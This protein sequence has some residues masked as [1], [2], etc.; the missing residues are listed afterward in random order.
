[1]SFWEAILLGLVQGLSEFVPISSTAHL[2]LAGRLLGRIDPNQPQE[3]TA[4][5]AVIQLGTLLAVVYYFRSDLA[6]IARGFILTHYVILR[7]EAPREEERTQSRLGWMVI[8][9]SI[10][11]GAVGLAFRDVIEGRL[12]K[13]LW[14]IAS[15][16][17]GVALL[18]A[19]AEV[20]GKQKRGL[21]EVK[22]IDAVVVGLAQVLALIPGS[23]RSGTTVAGGLFVGLRRETAARFSFL[24]SIPAIAASGLLELP[25][26]LGSTRVGWLELSAATFAAAI[27]GY[28]SI[29]FLLRYLAKHTTHLFVIYRLVLGLIVMGLLLKGVIAA[30]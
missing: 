26:A 11:I 10:P 2:T 22:L 23:S 6:G 13:N 15:S 8:I 1:M 7:G 16:L 3:W 12:T 17:I 4:F 25:D 19:L 28:L 20:V 30:D 18:L 21:G 27:S 24:I 29:E 5:I 9:A 14:V